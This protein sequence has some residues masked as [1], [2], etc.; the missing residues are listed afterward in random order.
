MF[1]A[2]VLSKVE[3]SWTTQ[4]LV[5]Q[6]MQ[7]MLVKGFLMQNQAVVLMSQKMPWMLLVTVV[8]VVVKG[9]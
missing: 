2:F 5:M 6:V 8:G 7:V 3:V 1:S 4:M 9:G